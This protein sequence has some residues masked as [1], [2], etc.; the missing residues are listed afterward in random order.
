MPSDLARP[1]PVTLSDP[2]DRIE[3]MFETS[4]EVRKWQQL[5][6]AA[7]ASPSGLDDPGRIDQIRLLE[8]LVCTATAAQ[9]LLSAELDCSVREQHRAAGEPTERQGRGVA[10]QVAYARRESPHRGQRH[11]GLAKIVANDLPHTWHAWSM[12]LITEWTATLIARETV[13]L[14]LDDRLAVDAEIASDPDALEQRG[15]AE[16]AGLC[17]AAAARLDPA[18]VV[19]RR[20][21]AEADRNVTL[22][23]APDTMTRLSGLL[24]VKDGVAVMATLSRAA[25]A[26]RAAGDPRS[27]GQVMADTLVN[28]ILG[29][30]SHTQTQEEPGVGVD[31]G[32]VMSD[33]SLFGDS[34]GPA[35]L[36][37]YGPIPAEL[38][39]E[40]VAD[41]CCNRENIWL[42]RLYTSPT[43][44]ELVTMDTRGRRFLHSLARFIRLRDQ[45]C[46][47]PW[48]AA[49]VRQADHAEDAASGGPTTATNGQGLCEACNR[50]K[51]APGWQAAPLSDA[52]GHEIKTTMPTGHH[53][54]SH[55]PPLIRLHHGRPTYVDYVLAG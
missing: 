13:C 37:G 32:L 53:Y 50:A 38:A 22:R 43:T 54:R 34:D 3:H 29:R 49:P 5:L 41:A 7:L 23:P 24:P 1:C 16:V 11:L 19:E 9:A 51:Q 31:L 18:S 46:R 35:H 26:A 4:T 42:R 39:R 52:D 15:S 12:G 8:Q 21:R 44:G 28:R 47:T 30:A 17:A 14:S 55:A 40:I 45:V 27:R 2:S 33:T 36:T 48:C 6:S 25:D 20:R 10:A